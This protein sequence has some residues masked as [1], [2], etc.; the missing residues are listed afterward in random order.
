MENSFDCKPPVRSDPLV[1]QNRDRLYK[2]FNSCPIPI[3][4]MLVNLGLFIRSG[5]LARLFFLQEIYQ[6]ILPIP[7]VVVEFGTWLGQSLC[8][9]ENLRAI[10]EPYNFTRKVFG[11]DTFEGYPEIGPNDVQS[12][13]IKRGRYCT[14]MGYED[15]L[16]ELLDYHEKENVMS[17]VKKHQI[18]KG[19]VTE[20]VPV[21][22]TGKP[23]IVV[24]LAFFDMALYEPTKICLETI[25]P[26][27][28]KGS[29]VA[30]DELNCDEYPGETMALMETL[31][32]RNHRIFRSQ[33]LP[34]RSYLIVD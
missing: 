6:L 22:F 7:G 2:L 12:E 15:F 1:I 21:F 17:H 14:A 20:T 29:V 10:N 11:F 23:E 24:A 34:D 3:D 19:N 32:L 33:Y 31:G 9:F 25:A 5:A 13:T 30:F 8:V 26:R 18:I 28:I 16:S 27:L 4:Q